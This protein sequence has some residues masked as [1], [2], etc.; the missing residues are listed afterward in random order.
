MNTQARGIKRN[1][2]WSAVASVAGTWTVTAYWTLV[3]HGYL[4][5]PWI[6]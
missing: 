1:I 6:V 3:T 5:T 4:D 2:L